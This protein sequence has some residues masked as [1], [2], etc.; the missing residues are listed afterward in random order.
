MEIIRI[1]TRDSQLALWQA[2]T[3]QRKLEDLGY[4]TK[5]VPVKSTG[6]L[7]LETP[8]YEMG[9]VG[10][11]TKTLDIALINNEI[12]IAVHSMKDVPTALPKTVVQTA[13]LER[14]NST[15][16]LVPREKE[17]DLNKVCVIANSSL[18][19]KT[20][21]LYKY[22]HHQVVPLRGNVNTRLRKLKEGNWD[23]AI[24]AKAGLERVNLLPQN[25]IELDWMIPAPAQGA[26]VI[27][28]HEKNRHAIEATQK[29]NHAESFQ[30]TL[31][32]RQFLRSLE[33]GCSAPIAAFAEIKNDH[34]K[35]KGNLFSWDG[36]KNLT[37][38][39]FYPTEDFMEI[40]KKAAQE[41]L[42]QGGKEIMIEIKKHPDRRKK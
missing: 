26:V 12:D 32:E 18:R 4:K 21:W 28:S 8:L 25:Y 22:P 24:F 33:G 35:F 7:N 5:L 10:I 31:I 13:V 2:T 15:D 16:I 3:V 9:I 17:I 6:D 37:I 41:I 40:G 38:D 27:V 20:Q 36:Q 29:L 34:I 39:K 19:R 42:D 23:A 14:G 30:T 1:G 11:F